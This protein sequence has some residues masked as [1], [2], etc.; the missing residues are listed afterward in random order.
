[1]SAK[2]RLL[3]QIKTQGCTTPIPN[4]PENFPLQLFGTI[5]Y[6]D[7]GKTDTGKT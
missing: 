4:G 7:D 6:C 2:L 1:M 3:R 5:I